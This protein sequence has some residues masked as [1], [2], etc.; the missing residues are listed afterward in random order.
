MIHSYQRR[1]HDPRLRPPAI[2]T[3]LLSLHRVTGPCCFIA[4]GCQHCLLT[5][6]IPLDP[7]FCCS[8]ISLAAKL[9]LSRGNLHLASF[10]FGWRS[11]GSCCRGL[12]RLRADAA[13]PFTTSNIL[14]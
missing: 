10:C 5:A 3:T 8:R 4:A 9:P 11:A 7:C 12:I 6:D 2:A 1:T 13:A 14:A